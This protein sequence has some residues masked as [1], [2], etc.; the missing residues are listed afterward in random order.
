MVTCPGAQQQRQA[1]AL[2][3][4]QFRG[5]VSDRS[6]VGVEAVTR[7]R[8]LACALCAEC[9]VGKLAGRGVVLGHCGS[10]RGREVRPS[11]ERAYAE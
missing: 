4:G 7:P 2:G 9:G 3:G 6:Y 5:A 10:L 11:D 8:G 1:L